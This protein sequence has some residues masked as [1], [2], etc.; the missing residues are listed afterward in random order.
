MGGLQ[1]A[2]MMVFKATR[3]TASRLALCLSAVHISDHC[4]TQ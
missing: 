4:T 1:N 3:Y 2:H